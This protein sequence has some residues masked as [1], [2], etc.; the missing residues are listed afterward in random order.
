[1]SVAAEVGVVG[2][3]MMRR[4]FLRT[5]VVAGGI[6]CAAVRAEEKAAAVVWRVADV[7]HVGGNATEIIG[8]PRVA[9]GAVEFDGVKDGLLVAANPLEGAREFTVEIL[10]RPAEGGLAE[11]RFLH[12]QD[13]GMSRALIET[14]LDGKGAGWLDTFLLKVM[15]AG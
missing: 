9:D 2:R 3:G 8:A 1:M 4:Y 11:Q 15:T 12:V 14:R 5:V 13:A 6:F 7:A 10:F